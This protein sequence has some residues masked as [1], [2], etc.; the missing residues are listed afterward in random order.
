[1]RRAAGGSKKKYDPGNA[2]R[3]R[4]FSLFLIFLPFFA[5]CN[6]FAVIALLGVICKLVQQ[7]AG[8]FAASPA[9][10][11]LFA[12]TAGFYRAAFAPKRFVNGYTPGA[13][14]RFP[15]G[16]L[17][18]QQAASGFDHNR[19]SLLVRFAFILAKGTG[20]QP[21]M[22]H[23]IFLEGPVPAEEALTGGI[24]GPALRPARRSSEPIPT[25]FH[26]SRIRVLKEA[27]HLWFL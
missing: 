23:N 2:F 21:V 13:G 9:V 22:F 4:I 24:Q 6:A 14:H 18:A 11:K 26:S 7:C 5:L 12:F 20:Q 25:Y 10:C 1:M 3:S 15:E 16:T 19:F 27:V 17:A 8:K